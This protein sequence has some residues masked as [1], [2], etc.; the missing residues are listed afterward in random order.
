VKAGGGKAKGAS[1]EREMC[2]KLSLWISHGKRQ[3]LLWRSSM[4][5]GRATIASRKGIKHQAVG[6]ICAVAPEGHKLTDHFFI[7]C[8]HVKKLDIASFILN[9]RGELAKFWKVACKQAR[10]HLRQP[11]LIAK[12]NGREPLVICKPRGLRMYCYDQPITLNP[13]I[14]FLSILLETR[15]PV[16]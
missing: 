6:D 4:S 14:R 2:V 11:L 8:K 7:E 9:N 13:E 3:D 1:F 10:E 16:L 5:G 12:E 15:F